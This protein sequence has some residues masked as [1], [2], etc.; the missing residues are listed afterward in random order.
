M[1]TDNHDDQ[2]SNQ[3]SSGYIDNG[4]HRADSISSMVSSQLSENIHDFEIIRQRKDLFEKGIDLF[5]QHPRKGLEY[6]IDKHLLNHQ[7]DDIAQFFHAY[8]DT[9]DKT[10]IGDCLGEEDKHHRQIMYAYV[11]QMD[12]VQMD[13]LMALRKFLAGFRLPGEAQKIDRLMEKFA[14]RYCECNAK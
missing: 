10:M 9:L 5:N 14:A 6:L 12:F 7:A 3:S 2:D 8:Q 1:S 13:F 4:I 11:D